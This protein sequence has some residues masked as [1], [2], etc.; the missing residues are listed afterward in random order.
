V[1]R[2]TVP[3]SKRLFTP[4]VVGRRAWARFGIP[5]DAVVEYNAL[6]PVAWLRDFKPDPTVLD[7]LGLDRDAPI[8]VLRPEEAFAAYLLDKTPTKSLIETLI[9]RLL[10]TEPV[11]QFVVVPRYAEQIE[12]FRAY[13]SPRVRV[14]ESAVDGASLLSY[15]SVFV[16]AGG[17]MTAEASLL[18]VPSL[19]CYP[20]EPYL[21]EKFLLRKGLLTRAGNVDE[22]IRYVQRVLA[23]PDAAKAVQ[24]RKAQRL[25]AEME[26]PIDIIA[27][28]VSAIGER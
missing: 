25:L 9:Q 21:V 13:R 15:S 3:I 18:G 26:D 17:T 11:A 8:V 4:K 28:G 16:G 10:K 1:A 23:D 22:A 14:S 19:S 2:L 12:A 20:N 27:Q 24:A 5:A 6:D 7:Q